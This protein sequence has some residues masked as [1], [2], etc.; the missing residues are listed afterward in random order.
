MKKELTVVLIARTGSTRCP[1]KVIKPFFNE[2]SL[3]EIMCKKLKTIDYPI[4]AAVGD[5]EL[6]D[7]ANKLNIPIFSRTKEEVTIGSPLVKVFKCLEQC[8]TSHAMLVSPCTPFLSV[9]TIN[10]S[11]R[12]FCESEEWDSMSAIMKEQNWFFDEDRKPLVPIDIKVMSTNNLCVYAMANAYDIFP[13]DRFLK[14]GIFY[15]FD[16]LNDPYL[17]EIPKDETF[18][19]DDPDDFELGRHIYAYRMEKNQVTV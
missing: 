19:I 2:T 3:F 11:C 17:Y 16:T 9:E 6:I 10:T 7:L 12:L 18:D 15:T 1:R 5:P 8:K 13:V 4:A 14:D